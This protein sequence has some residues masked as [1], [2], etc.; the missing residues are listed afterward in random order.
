PGRR[1]LKSG[2]WSGHGSPTAERPMRE[3][4]TLASGPADHVVNHV[5]W[6][7]SGGWWLW[8]GNQGNL[9]LSGLLMILGFLWFARQVRTGPESQ[10]SGRYLTRN[11]FAHAIEVICVY[12]RDEIVKP[13]LG[14]RTDRF[15]PILWTIFFF[16]LIN[17][18]LGLVPIMDLLHVIFPS[19][20][21]QH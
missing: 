12:L 7:S 14:D 9:L 3:L 4:L 20:E 11:R 16:V 19:W 18:I 1:S 10:A 6:K 5:W 13:M 15:M 2:G 21:E 8:S 17:N